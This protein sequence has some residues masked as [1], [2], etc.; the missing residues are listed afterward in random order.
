MHPAFV[1]LSV[2]HLP[3]LA[4]GFCSFSLCIKI[5]GSTFMR[6]G[7]QMGH[8]CSHAEDTSSL[9]PPYSPFLQVS[10]S[11]RVAPHCAHCAGCPAGPPASLVLVAL[12]SVWLYFQ[13]DDERRHR[14]PW[15]EIEQAHPLSYNEGT[16]ISLVS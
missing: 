2:L 15:P 10:N 6:T 8:S 13:P 9:T 16:I 1:S 4:L 3:H 14:Q 11:C 5:A 7:V 12:T